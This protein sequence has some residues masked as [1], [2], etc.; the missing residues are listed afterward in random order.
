M[1]TPFKVR[2]TRVEEKRE[3]AGLNDRLEAYVGLN[4]TLRAAADA[5]AAKLEASASAYENRIQSLEA[6]YRTEIDAL[7]AALTKEGKR[8]AAAE[9]RGDALGL[10]V[11]EARS[12]LAGMKALAAANAQLEV[13]LAAANA[14]AKATAE[15]AATLEAAVKAEHERAT[16]LTSENKD[17]RSQ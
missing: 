16:A 5:A 11:V 12:Q 2:E 17:L 6:G 7:K 8:A 14:G 10:D 15:K 13:K 3:L 4:K 1:A 9:Q